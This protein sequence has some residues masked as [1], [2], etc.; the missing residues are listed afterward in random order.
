M[1]SIL[2][3][4]VAISAYSAANAAEKITLQ[5][6]PNEMQ[7]LS[8]GLSVLDGYHRIAKGPMGQDQD[9]PTAYDISA[10][11]RLTIA[12]DDAVAQGYF[13]DVRKATKG[14]TG[15]KLMEV[16]D[17]KQAVEML[18][19]DVRD[20]NVDKNPFPPSAL[21]DLAPICPSCVDPK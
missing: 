10:S 21:A 5:L 4:V 2:V 17:A 13:T 19:I 11:A 7:R 20:L 12:H 1:K 3:A 9:V 6:S 16:V 18:T 14:L 8:Q 15:D